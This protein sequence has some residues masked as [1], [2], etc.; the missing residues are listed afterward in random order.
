MDIRGGGDLC[1]L[2]FFCDW[3]VFVEG[4]F[5]VVVFCILF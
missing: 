5:D 4:D 2:L 3:Y 1:G